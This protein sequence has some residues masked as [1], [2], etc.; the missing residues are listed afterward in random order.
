M[1]GE[2]VAHIF[3]AVAYTFVFHLGFK[4]R[5]TISRLP[6]NDLEYFLV[7]TFFKGGLRTLFWYLFLTFR[8]TTYLFEEFFVEEC[9]ITNMCSTF[10]STYLLLW[11]DINLRQ[12]IQGFFAQI[13]RTVYSSSQCSTLGTWAAR[14]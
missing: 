9:R 1:F 14:Y 11:G 7:D 13:I 3:R 6:N 8:T 12:G 4:L 10:I 2:T 5:G